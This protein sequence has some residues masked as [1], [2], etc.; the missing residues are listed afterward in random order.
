MKYLLIVTIN[1]SFF[2]QTSAQSNFEGEYKISTAGDTLDIKNGTVLALKCN[3]TFTQYDSGGIVYGKW[4]IKNKNKLKLEF[5]SMSIN[6]KTAASNTKLEYRI[7]EGKIHS[8]TITTEE[9]ND[10]KKLNANFR[11]KVQKF[12]DYK[13]I[14]SKIYFLRYLTYNCK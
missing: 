7:E 12:S 13:A 14:L 1:L 10:Y 2:I 3:N 8:R 6:G 11:G 4:Y 5:D 9:Y